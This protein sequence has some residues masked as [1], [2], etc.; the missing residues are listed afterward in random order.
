MYYSLKLP[1]LVQENAGNNLHS[2]LNTAVIASEY[3]R[4]LVRD[5]KE[6]V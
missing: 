5:R 3:F 1:V 6:E 2:D 4:L